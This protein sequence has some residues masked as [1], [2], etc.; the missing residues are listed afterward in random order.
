M[1][2]RDILTFDV[3]RVLRYDVNRILRADVG[4][5]LTI[6]LKAICGSVTLSAAQHRSNSTGRRRDD[7][8]DGASC[9][10]SPSA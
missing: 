9:P 1:S 8:V 2:L 6:L 10:S 4:A 7:P 3:N 5:A